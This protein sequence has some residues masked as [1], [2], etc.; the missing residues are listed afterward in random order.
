MTRQR[1]FISHANPADNDAAAWLAA[2]LTVL[3]YSVWVDVEKLK[4]GE[5]IWREIEPVLRNQCRSL[6]LLL[7][8]S[9]YGQDGLLR[10]GV[11]RE[12]ELGLTLE[13]ELPEFVL[14]WIL[15]D[16]P[17][18]QL[19]IQI[20]GRMSVPE[21]RWS[22]ALARILEYLGS[23][24]VEPSDSP[25]EGSQLLRQLLIPE[26]IGVIHQETRYDINR[27]ACLALPEKIFSVVDDHSVPSEM[28]SGAVFAGR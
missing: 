13:R 22:T 1:I 20:H 3:G 6:I 9:T 18:Q 26:E 2:K 11:E 14:P 12:M 10:Q 21:R 7:S 23:I 15:D 8:R 25:S 28:V 4:G 17:F 19:P 16:L 24:G 5:T 27:L